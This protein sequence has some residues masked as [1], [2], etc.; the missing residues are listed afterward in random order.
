MVDWSNIDTVLLDMDGTLLDLHFDNHFWLTHV[1][2][3][4]ADKHGMDVEQAMRELLSQYREVEGSLDWYCVD[5]W[6]DKLGLDIVQLKH[7][8]SHKI[9]IRPKVIQFLETLRGLSIDVRLVTNA[10]E[11]AIQ[12]KMSYT[13]LAPHFDSIVCSHVIGAPK[14]SAEFWSL[15]HQRYP[16][17]SQRTLFV[18][19]NLEVLR[20]ARSHG[21]RYLLA[22]YQPDSQKPVREVAEFSAIHSF[23]E[24]MP[25]SKFTRIENEQSR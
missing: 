2:H 1:P 12:I 21:I 23:D 7:E 13:G 4:F 3:H 24:I 9:S 5:Y 15:L 20:A 10:H 14:E 17:D 11:K 25:Q 18:D 22:V 6:S 16:F 19:D 8:V